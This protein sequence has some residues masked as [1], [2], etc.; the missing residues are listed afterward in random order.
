M[1]IGNLLKK[2]AEKGAEM[3]GEAAKRGIAI[4]QE[5]GFMKT[6]EEKEAERLEAKR[7]AEEARLEAERKAEEERIEKARLDAEEK[8]K[9]LAEALKPT[10]EKGDCAWLCEKFY[11]TCG[12]QLCER[13]K[14]S[15][16]TLIE[17]PEMW[18][19]IKRFEAVAK[20]KE[21]EKNG[22]RNSKDIARFVDWVTQDF[23]NDFCPNLS[24]ADSPIYYVID[25]ITS[26]HSFDFSCFYDAKTSNLES[27]ISRFRELEFFKDINSVEHIKENITS[28]KL[29]K[30]FEILH[31]NF[32]EN[33][34][35][36]LSMDFFKN[37][38]LYN[39]T[40]REYCYTVRLLCTV[41]IPKKL[42]EMF[43]DTSCIHVEDLFDEHGNILEVGEGGPKA[44]FYG[45]C[46]YNI[47]ETW[48]GPNGSNNV[49][50]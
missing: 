50:Y 12:G 37:P 44:G 3:A 20:M 30:T 29:K 21:E 24:D 43:K 11:C 8:E 46:L 35:E 10:C 4:A 14:Y 40:E 18:S 48:S 28:E 5:N 16:P 36:L 42:Q 17:N 41:N 34:E 45:D 31:C 38:S 39:R 22:T 23:V 49:D 13:K 2:A 33:A 27:G 47:V 26:G 7:K 25:N 32:A 15:N 1:G 6:E 19:Y 9:W